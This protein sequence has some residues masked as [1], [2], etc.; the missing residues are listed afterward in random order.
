MAVDPTSSAAATSGSPGSAG[1]TS[2]TSL[3]LDKTAFL[4][5]LVAQL[6]YQNPLNPQDGAQYMA[7]LAQFASVEQL[8]NI[9]QAQHDSGMWQQALMGSSM[10]GKEVTG[11]GPG[12]AT[13]DGQVT[14]MKLT[15]SGPL[16]ELEGGG[17]L[18]VQDV[19]QVGG[20]TGSTTS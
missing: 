11:T 12:G 15:S 13:V 3:G 16:L 6:K 5:L 9:S 8:T 17:T 4:Q 1:P 20:T 2:A 18:S 7:Q 10:I 19:D 14:G